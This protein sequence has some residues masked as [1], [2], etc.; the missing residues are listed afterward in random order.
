METAKDILTNAL[1]AK[2]MYVIYL[3]IRLAM[4]QGK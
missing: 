1:R 4:T 2:I 3:E